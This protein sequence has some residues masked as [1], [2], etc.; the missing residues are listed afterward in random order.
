MGDFKMILKINNLVK[1]FKNEEVIKS[2]SYDFKSGNIYG[3]VGR[4][5]SGK[6]VL[7]KV[8][9]GLYKQDSG[10]VLFD[11]INYND[12]NNFPKNIGIAIE[13]PA[14]INDL[15]GYENLKLLASIQNKIGKDGILDSLTIVNLVNDKDKLYKKYS[16]GM[17]QKLSLAQA[18]MEKPN[19]LLLDEPF[20]GIE[21]VSVEKI[22]AYLRELKK[23]NKLI[24]ITTHI[25]DDLIDLCD[26]LL[27]INE[28]VLKEYDNK[29]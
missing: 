11:G 20:N 19:I 12:G 7:L 17:K 4:N 3:I 24:I 26:I 25:K 21:R 10:D 1:K 16:L 22:K 13:E 14:F 28:G 18:F 2:L 9:A 8:I 29:K 27:E 23:Q 15:T 6:S 5:G